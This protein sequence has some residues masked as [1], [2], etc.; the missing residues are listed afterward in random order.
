MKSQ[1]CRGRR[2]DAKLT[3]GH[4]FPHLDIPGLPAG[5]AP[6]LLSAAADEPVAA[7]AAGCILFL[8]RVVE[9]VLLAAGHLLHGV[10]LPAGGPD[11]PLPAARGGGGAQTTRRSARSISLDRVGGR[12][13]AGDRPGVQRMACPAGATPDV[14]RL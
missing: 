3:G 12:A 6:D 13:A 9:P 11:G 4:A 1:A 8:L 10:G 14:H 7:V 2:K 5:R